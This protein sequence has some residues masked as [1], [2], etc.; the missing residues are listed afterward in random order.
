VDVAAGEKMYGKQPYDP[1][2]DSDDD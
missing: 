1:N 2:D